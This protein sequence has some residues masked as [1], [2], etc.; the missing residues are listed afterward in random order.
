MRTSPSRSS[1]TVR[2]RCPSPSG[3]RLAGV[4]PP[5]APRG[6][7]SEVR[8]PEEPRAHR[9]GRVAQRP[10]QGTH[11][12]RVGLSGAIMIPR[13]AH[14]AGELGAGNRSADPYVPLPVAPDRL[15]RH[16]TM[17]RAS[18]GRVDRRMNGW[19][20]AVEIVQ[21]WPIWISIWLGI[22][23]WKRP[24]I[25]RL[26]EKLR[27]GE[28]EVQVGSV[29]FGPLTDS[30]ELSAEARVAEKVAPDALDEA[31]DTLRAA[32]ER[33]AASEY[34]GGASLA[35]SEI[36]LKP[37]RLA[38]QALETLGYLRN[39]EYVTIEFQTGGRSIRDL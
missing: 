12:S 27:L 21:S 4:S 17:W 7:S 30:E 25:E 3:H 15:P 2:I 1:A 37:L 16:L 28:R 35:P 32:N 10:E 14:V 33:A 31:L 34:V 9:R 13:E 26:V 11:N 19:E 23:I 6:R 24:A 38:S 5:V 39:E 18:A 8:G 36:E 20:A 22:A 29:R